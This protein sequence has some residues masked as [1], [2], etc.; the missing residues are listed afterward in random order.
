MGGVQIHICLWVRIHSHLY[1]QPRMDDEA[2][3][4][5]DGFSAMFNI[6]GYSLRR[7][8]EADK[9][10]EEGISPWKIGMLAACLLLWDIMWKVCFA[11]N[12]FCACHVLC[13]LHGNHGITG[14]TVTA[15]GVLITYVQSDVRY[16]DPTTRPAG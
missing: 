1:T 4:A 16:V 11:I 2:R 9:S 7:G 6:R 13:S 3:D 14:G 12:R 10:A 5:F 8:K 15:R